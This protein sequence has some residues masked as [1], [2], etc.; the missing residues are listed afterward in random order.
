MLPAVKIHA[1][2]DSEGEASGRRQDHKMI[3]QQRPHPLLPRPMAMTSESMA[4][5][6]ALLARL[7]N[8]ASR[9]P[10]PFPPPFLAKSPTS[11][12]PFP[13]SAAAFP[14]SLHPHMSD[15]RARLLGQLV[16]FP[17][18]GDGGGGERTEFP[19]R[20]L[21]RPTAWAT[22]W[23][24][25]TTWATTSTISPGMAQSLLSTVSQCLKKLSR[26][27]VIISKHAGALCHLHKIALGN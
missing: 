27:K 14:P 5:S 18:G 13:P 4:A 8:N 7:T 1:C 22:C 23:Q 12:F 25:A 16:P 10:F 9:P 6:A 20:T 11:P 17:H 26:L 24:L 15:L 21:A 3:E 19:S 2:S